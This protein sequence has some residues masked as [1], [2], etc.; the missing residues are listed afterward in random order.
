MR[1]KLIIIGIVS[2]ALL[3]LALLAYINSLQ[4][5]A[6]HTFIT[7][8]NQELVSRGKIIYENHCAACHGAK[9]EGQANWRE[10]MP[11]GRL[12]APPHDVTGH[13]WHHPDAVLVDIIK[14]GLVPG[15]TA[16]DDYASDMPAYGKVL[17]DSDIIAVLAYIK[18]S[19]PA[20]TLEM[21]KSLT[22]Q[23]QQSHR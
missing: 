6:E 23:H 2:A 18:S 11:N 17:S 4:D 15:R 16:P 13:T 22:L 7:P 19:W 3:G 12:P 14:N 5:E 10:R 1:K 9:L 21:Q 8:A 20:E